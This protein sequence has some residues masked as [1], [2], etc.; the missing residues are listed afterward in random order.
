M[1]RSKKEHKFVDVQGLDVCVEVMFESNLSI[2][3][4]R[5]LVRASRR[6]AVDLRDALQ[7]KETRTQPLDENI[8][9]YNEMYD[10][11]CNHEAPSFRPSRTK[12]RLPFASVPINLH[13]QTFQANNSSWYFVTCGAIAAIP[14]RFESGGLSRLRETLN[15]KFESTSRLQNAQLLIDNLAQRI[16]A[17]WHSGVTSEIKQLF[18]RIQTIPNVSL[19]YSSQLETLKKTKITDR[20]EALVVLDALKEL[21]RT[22][23]QEESMYLALQ[24][25]PNAQ[26]YFHIQL[27]YDVVLS[28]AITVIATCLLANVEN[29]RNEQLVNWKPFVSFFGFLSYHKNEKGMI[30]DMQEIWS[31]FHDRVRFCFDSTT[32]IDWQSTCVD[33]TIAVPDEVIAKL[34]YERGQWFRVRT[35][36]WNLSVNKSE[37]SVPLE[38]KINLEALSATTK[39]VELNNLKPGP[40]LE[41]LR[42]TVEKSPFNANLNIFSKVQALTRALKGSCVLSCQSGKDRTAMAV[43]FDEAK[44]LQ[45]HFTVSQ[46]Q[47]NKI[48]DSLR[49]DGVRR[50]NCRK[51]VGKPM[52][53][54][55]SHRVQSMPKEFRP[56]VDTYIEDLEI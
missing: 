22:I 36:Y 18:D 17:H 21:V 33:V 14:L 38:K 10:F 55:S 48:V 28:Q 42:K 34:P 30:E 26:L 46:D 20:K 15:S 37:V 29:S 27:R 5:E 16:S 13:L 44:L 12:Y 51:N 41:D 40:L 2:A 24:R 6:R 43:T 56:P 11:L 1:R 39:F 25:P 54:C 23:S 47:F 49:R 8:K 19:L 45:E 3:L 50:E 31:V 53:A 52:Y 7:Q 32:N 35:F 9:V 4:P